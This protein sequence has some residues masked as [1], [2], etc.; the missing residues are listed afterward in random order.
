MDKFDDSALIN[1]DTATESELKIAVSK[2]RNG[3]AG[4]VDGIRP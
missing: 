1:V 3:S 2:F 4:G